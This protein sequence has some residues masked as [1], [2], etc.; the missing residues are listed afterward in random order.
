MI[1]IKQNWN[2]I[3]K[4]LIFLLDKVMFIAKE[5]VIVMVMSGVIAVIIAL[6]PSEKGAVESETIQL[7]LK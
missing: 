1:V 4:V 2:L 5:A 6:H 3:I 7:R